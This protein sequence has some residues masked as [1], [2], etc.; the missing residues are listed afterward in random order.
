MANEILIKNGTQ[1]V[2]ADT[3]D[4]GD[5]PVARTVQLDLTSLASGAARQ[6]VKV[7]LGETRA[8]RQ[9]VTLRFEFDVA[10][11]SPGKGVSVYWA[12][13]ESGTAGVA[14]PGGVDGTDSAYTGTAGDSIADS[15]AQLQLIGI[16][17]VTSDAAAVVNQ[18]TWALY[19]LCR[20]GSPVI[21]NEANQ[22][23]EG[24]AIE[25]SLIFTPVIDEIQ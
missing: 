16:L 24:D 2:W 8:P 22:A 9:D 10:P 4:F 3:T 23:A 25:M 7:D 19:P 1:I 5:S 11:A 18:Q 13:S 20:Y 17:V 6:G 15:I 14:N 12:P 21:W